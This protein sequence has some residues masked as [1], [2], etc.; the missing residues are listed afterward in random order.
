MAFSRPCSSERACENGATQ[1]YRPVTN[2]DVILG[3]VGVL[4][5]EVVQYRLHDEY[6]VESIFEA[7][8]VSTAR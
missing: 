7:A 3:A 6:S 4:Q 1:I 8:T 2:N 5:F